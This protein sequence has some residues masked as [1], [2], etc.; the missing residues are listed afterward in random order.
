MPVFIFAISECS[1]ISLAEQIF[2]CTRAS[3]AT[4]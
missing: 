4:C 2:E 1:N 3:A